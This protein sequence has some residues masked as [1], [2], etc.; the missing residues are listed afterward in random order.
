MSLDITCVVR[1]LGGEV[2]ATRV[3]KIVHGCARK[4][5]LERNLLC[6]P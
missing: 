4:I 2:G 3:V 6:Q 5:I 1:E